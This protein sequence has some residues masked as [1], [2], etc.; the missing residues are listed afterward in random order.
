ME[1]IPAPQLWPLSG[2]EHQAEQVLLLTELKGVLR[3]L[4]TALHLLEL[5][6][7]L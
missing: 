3:L 7:E 4:G 1:R 2:L 5:E 6:L